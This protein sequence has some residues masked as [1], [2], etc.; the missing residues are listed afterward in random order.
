MS[1]KQEIA[2]DELLEVANKQTKTFIEQLKQEE[3][4]ERVET[5]EN[6]MREIKADSENSEL[7]KKLF[8]QEI[9]NGLGQEIKQNRGVRRV[10]KTRWQKI[11]ESI[12]RFI[13]LMK[14]VYRL[15]WRSIFKIRKRGTSL[16][17]TEK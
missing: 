3:K 9:K 6:V 11:K 8:I 10:E 1:K 2:L 4:I 16:L 5:E 14:L 13:Y 15:P 7:K 17:L 12:C